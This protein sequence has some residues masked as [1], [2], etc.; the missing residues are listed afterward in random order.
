MARLLTGFRASRPELQVNIRAF[1]CHQ[2]LFGL[3]QAGP[4]VLTQLQLPSTQCV[5]LEIFDWNNKLDKFLIF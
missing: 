5:Q 1:F 2:P 3:F 4:L